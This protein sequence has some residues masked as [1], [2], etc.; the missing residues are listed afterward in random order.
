MA[1]SYGASPTPWCLSD[2][3]G[4]APAGTA[5]H[6]PSSWWWDWSKV[7]LDRQSC[8][9]GPRLVRVDWMQHSPPITGQVN[10]D[11]MGLRPVHRSGT[12]L[13]GSMA[14]LEA[15]PTAQQQ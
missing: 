8:W 9:S 12:R 3:P 11:K 4:P 15:G 6:Q 1:S 7:K 2:T 5:T 14:L 13:T 10:S